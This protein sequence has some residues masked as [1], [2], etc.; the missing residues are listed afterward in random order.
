MNS[1]IAYGIV[2][3]VPSLLALASSACW[4]DL[5]HLLIAPFLQ[6]HCLSLVCCL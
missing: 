4:L 6:Q 2:L 3:S 5:R 1:I